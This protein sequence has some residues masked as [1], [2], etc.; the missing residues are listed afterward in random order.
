MVAI[1]GQTTGQPETPLR[2]V[3]SGAEV[4]EFHALARQVLCGDHLLRYVAELLRATHPGDGADDATCRFVRYGA[5]PRAGQAIIL[6]AKVRALLDGRPS[7]AR[8][9]LEHCMIHALRHR[10]VLTFEAEAESRDVASMLPA[11]CKLARER[12]DAG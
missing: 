12:A 2:T 8:E 10:I 6:G 7:V 11:W 5:S 3:L 1:L 9:D 4:L